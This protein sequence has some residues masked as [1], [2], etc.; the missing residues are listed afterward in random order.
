MQSITLLTYGRNASLPAGLAGTYKAAKQWEDAEE[1]LRRVV[2]IETKTFGEGHPRVARD[3]VSIGF[4]V[5]V[6]A[7]LDRKFSQQDVPSGTVAGKP[8]D[9][10]EACWAII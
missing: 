10:V 5:P 8:G 6:P 9:C 1:C 4:L 7:A 2:E 3:K